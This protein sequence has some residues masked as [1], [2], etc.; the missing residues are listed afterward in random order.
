MKIYAPG[1]L[2]LSG[3]HAV[4]YGK[5]A[6]AMAVNR[7]AMVTIT[8]ETSK[9]VSFDFSDVAFTDCLDFRTLMQSKNRIQYAFKRYANGD[10]GIRDVLR[11][12]Y[13]LG[14]FTLALLLERLNIREGLRIQLTSGIPMGCGM[15]SSAATIVSLIQ[16]IASYVNVPLKTLYPCAMEA[17][18]AQ[19]GQSSGLDLQI[20]L[21]GGCHYFKNRQLM[22]RPMPSQTIYYIQTG[23]P[24]TTTGECVAAAAHHFLTS[25]VGDDFE[26]V[27]NAMDKG[28]DFKQTVRANHRLLATIGVVPEKVQRFIS[29]IEKMQGAAKICGAGSIKGDA[30][31][32]VLAVLDDVSQLKI[33]CERYQY[34]MLAISG[35]SRGVYVN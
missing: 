21:Q 12:P 6:L 14:Q 28:E 26:N 8:P 9:Q 17:E 24:E 16:A 10:I 34:E 30:A 25:S 13:E 7:Y 32:V 1:K 18:N 27:T 23:K 11:H 3:E 35:E 5:P 29:D 22:P 20:A 2:I 33:V 31:G 19:H 4:V 15:G